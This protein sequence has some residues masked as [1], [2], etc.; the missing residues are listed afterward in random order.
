MRSSIQLAERQN[1]KRRA[2][3]K[4]KRTLADYEQACFEEAMETGPDPD[5]RRAAKKETERLRA[6]VIKLFTEA[7]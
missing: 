2:R 5:Y 4:F 1:R 3:D 6:K 7:Q